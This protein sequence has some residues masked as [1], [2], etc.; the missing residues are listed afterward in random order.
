[1]TR[2]LR[3]CPHCGCVLV[4]PRYPKY[5]KFFFAV[6]AA[7]FDNWPEDHPLKPRDAETL[8]GMLMVEVGEYDTVGN[9]YKPGSDN[10]FKLMDFIDMAVH[11]AR[12]SGY[13]KLA[14]RDDGTAEAR[15]PRSIAWDKMDQKE[16][17]PIAEKIFELVEAETHLR[18]ADLRRRT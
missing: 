5:H 10:V 9:G 8:R 7:A 1:M 14:L 4:Q 13:T 11:A 16:F 12:L 15:F 2:R 6:L 3:H 17:G 18:I